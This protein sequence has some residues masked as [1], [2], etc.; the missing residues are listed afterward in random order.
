MVCVQK[1]FCVRCSE[2]NTKHKQKGNMTHGAEWICEPVESVTVKQ[3]LSTSILMLEPTK[4]ARAQ[5]IKKTL[6]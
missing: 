4:L 2:V 6:R 5:E 3:E 1:I